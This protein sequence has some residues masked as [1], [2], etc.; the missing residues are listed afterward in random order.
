LESAETLS[1]V[2]KRNQ[3]TSSPLT[4][5]SLESIKRA[6]HREA[7]YGDSMNPFRK[8]PRSKTWDVT[9]RQADEEA[10][11]ASPLSHINSEPAQKAPP[12]PSPDAVTSP[13]QNG[14]LANG[15][16]AEMTNALGNGARQEQS[17]EETAVDKSIGRPPSKE[18]IVRRRFFSRFRKQKDDPENPRM[19]TEKST[20]KSSKKSLKHN[21]FTVGNQLRATIFN[22]WVNILLIAAPVGIAL[23]FVNANPVA[24][25]VVNFI[26]IVPLAAL[27]SFGTEEIS[28]RV[29]ETLGGLLNASFGFVVQVRISNIC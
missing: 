1:S 25:F 16:K 5:L 15:E 17:S 29:G 8:G 27:L 26:A 14:G 13:D 24:I 12:F 20:G 22:S 10:V 3:L 7:W 4:Y 21:K 2:Q 9:A 28:L 6:A 19:A 18:H 23:H 11:P